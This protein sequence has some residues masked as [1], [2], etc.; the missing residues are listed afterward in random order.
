[1]GQRYKTVG[2]EVAEDKV[3]TRGKPGLTGKQKLQGHAWPPWGENSI[4]CLLQDLTQHQHHL[5]FP[6]AE[7][8]QKSVP[9]SSHTQVLCLSNLSV[10]LQSRAEHRMVLLVPEWSPDRL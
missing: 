9:D 10:S 2:S 3:G 8:T 6:P 4:P 7:R 5:R 1:M